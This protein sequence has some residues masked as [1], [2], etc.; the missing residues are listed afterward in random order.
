MRLRRLT[1]ALVAASLGGCAGMKSGQ[2]S[3]HPQPGPPARTAEQPVKLRWL[4]DGTLATT[5]LQ[6]DAT[7]PYWLT[8][9]AGDAEILNVAFQASARTL[10]V[11][12]F[13]SS[14]PMHPTCR[15]RDEGSRVWYSPKACVE[16]DFSHLYRVD[17]GPEGLIAVHSSAEGASAVS[18]ARYSVTA[19]QSPALATL[20]LQGASAIDVG[21]APDASRID[22]VSPCE[23]STRVATLC[24]PDAAA[25]WKLYSLPATGGELTLRRDD[26]PPGT[27]FDSATQRFAWPRGSE[28]CI[29]D[30]REPKPRC[31]PL[32]QAR[33]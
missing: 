12:Q 7:F 27:A 18:V 33:K 11:Q 6:S 10:V 26:L 5:E 22:F 15:A 19:G 29:E 20:Q 4:R 14:D 25:R 28:V 31:S 3:A 23:L 32:A 13:A 2:P 24:D 8:G 30:P 16:A 1:A 9:T 21:F 17:A